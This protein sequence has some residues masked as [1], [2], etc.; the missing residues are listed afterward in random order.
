MAYESTGEAEATDDDKKIL[1]EAREYL[2]QCVDEEDEERVKMQ[3]DLRFCTLDQWPTDIRNE[4][5]GDVENGPRPCLTIDKINQYIVQVVNDMRQGKPG[6]NVRPQDNAADVQTAKILKGLVRNIEDQSSA[7]IAYM[8]AGESAARIGLGYF[9]ITAE[10]AAEDS[11]D[12]ELF[13]RPIPNTFSV[14][15]GKHIMPDGSDAEHGFIVE[16]IPVEKFKEMYPKA[17]VEQ[18]EFDGLDKNVMGYWRTAETITVVEYYCIKTTMQKLHFLADGTTIE[19][20]D[21]KVWPEDV[22]GPRPE[23]QETRLAQKRQLKWQ[24]ITGVEVLDKRDLPG[25]W[26][27]IVEVVGREAWVDGRRVVWG[28]VRPAKDSLRMYNYWAST[29]TEKMALAPKTPYV[30]AKGQFEGLEERWKKANRV[31]FAY[32]EYNPIDVNGNALPV[33]QRQGA[34]PMEAA[35][36]QQMQVIEH[37][38]QTSLG[39]FKAATGESESQQSGRAI[40]ALQRESDT[41]TYHFGAN[42][43]ISIRHA[44]RILVDLIPHYYDTKRIVRILGEDGEVQPVMIDP[45]QEMAS[46]QVQTNDGMKAIYN[47]GVGKYDVSVSVGP[48]YNTKRVEAQATFVEMAKGA[49]DPMSAAVLRYLTVRNSDFHGSEEAAKM[50]K[51]LLPPPALAALDSGQQMPAAAV[52]QIAQAKQAVQMLQQEL[53]QEQ[54]GT[55]QAM[56]KVQADHDAKMKALALDREV[57]AQKLKDARDKAESDYNLRKWQAEREIE[58]ANMQAAAEDSRAEK[59]LTMEREQ[60]AT[61]NEFQRAEQQKTEQERAMPQFMDALKQI[62]ETF[63]T[64]L[65]Q[66]QQSTERSLALIAEA[67]KSKPGQISIGSIKR[68]NDGMITQASASI[69]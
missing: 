18:K 52:A 2:K 41:G 12:Q 13:I 40:L 38:V 47:P 67:I 49:A 63:A 53:Q 36:L 46:R 17:K 30:G 24:K 44:G 19:D 23:I 68:N 28:L 60:Q 14:Y 7:D 65:T 22:A 64:A 8:I 10:Y 27:P 5:E 33:P 59:K 21:Y 39:M 1:E 16:S 62:T 31:N 69:N 15:L 29:I 57:E 3:D 32:L 51:A 45:E 61:E 4:R 11:F 42:L 37:D 55:K 43:G 34:T 26:I 25:R 6:I 56:V 58:L 66:Q 54:A 50:L 48:S 9:R 35:L 20:A